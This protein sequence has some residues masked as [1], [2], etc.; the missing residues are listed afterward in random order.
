MA[1]ETKKLAPSCDKLETVYFR[2]GM[3]VKL[4]HASDAHLGQGI[5]GEARGRSTS[6]EMFFL[7]FEDLLKLAHEEEVDLLL[8][9]G[10]ILESSRINTADVRRIRSLLEAPRSFGI[11]AVAGNHDPLNEGSPW[12]EIAADLPNF[13]LFS[14][15][16]IERIDIPTL[17]L[18][19]YGT[20]FHHL[21]ESPGLLPCQAGWL[22]GNERVLGH[23]GLGRGLT[24]GEY[25]NPLHPRAPLS[26]K[27]SLIH[28][29]LGS[30]LSIEEA[31]AGH[32]YNRLGSDE[33]R[34]SGVDYVALGH[35]HL[36]INERVGETQYAYSG[37]PQGAG[38]DELGQRGAL[39]GTW[40]GRYPEFQLYPLARSHYELVELGLDGLSDDAETARFILEMLRDRDIESYGVHR[41]KITLTGE[42]LPDYRPDLKAI[43][44]RL[45]SDLAYVE[46]QDLTRPALGLEQIRLEE[47]LRGAYVRALD[48][49]MASNKFA[50]DQEEDIFNLALRF[51]LDAMGTEGE[52]EL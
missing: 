43:E 21:Y 44:M 48:K 52:L 37:T 29:D 24:N 10:D 12:L 40:R 35:Y 49:L 34:R 19:I 17:D 16:R 30:G 8:L 32:G 20:S 25:V 36:S 50:T 28:G 27:L 51:G 31:S 7:V 22:E 5:R 33:L 2:G 46:I 38:F 47:G 14:S 13:Y 23:V 11:L 45:S 3:D 4:L 15:R 41:Y 18:T 26:H 6:R 9:A 1:F 39:L 42:R